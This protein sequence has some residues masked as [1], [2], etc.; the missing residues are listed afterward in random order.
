[1]ISIAKYEVVLFLSSIVGLTSTN[2]APFIFFVREMASINF[3]SV[4]LSIP[5][6][7]GTP[8]PGAI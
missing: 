8:V 6:G 3:K 5:F 1:M 4:F 2:S 7:T